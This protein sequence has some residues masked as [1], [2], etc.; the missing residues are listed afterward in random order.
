MRG[1]EDLVRF[2]FHMQNNIKLYHWQTKSFA[3]H[4][5]SDELYI[6]LID[7]VDEFIEMYIGRYSRPQFGKTSVIEIEEY[8]DSE[9]VSLLHKYI[10]FLKDDLHEYLVPSD[11]DL[12]NIRDSIIGKLN[13]TVYLFTLN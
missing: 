3:R 13:Q 2:F 7:L 6:A 5:A 8:H 10:A 9:I 11:T 4:K 1:C 12:L